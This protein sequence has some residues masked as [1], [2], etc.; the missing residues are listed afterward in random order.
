M[1]QEGK[2]HLPDQNGEGPWFS[3][4]AYTLHSEV[5][6]LQSPASQVQ[7]SEVDDNVKVLSQLHGCVLL[8]DAKT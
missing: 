1:K 8:E 6:Q 7:G 5:P 3:S 2:F 4:S